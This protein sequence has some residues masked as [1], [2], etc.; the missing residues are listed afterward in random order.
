M[1]RGVASSS[2][3]KRSHNAESSASGP[4][5]QRS[6]SLHA[7]LPSQ[8]LESAD[9]KKVRKS[10]T[11]PKP[12]RICPEERFDFRLWAGGSREE[13]A[14]QKIDYMKSIDDKYP[15]RKWIIQKIEGSPYYMECIDSM[16]PKFSSYTRAQKIKAYND[17]PLAIPGS[18]PSRRTG[19]TAMG[20]RTT[21]P[22]AG[23]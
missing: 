15:L 19:G 14:K 5:L 12:D 18:S 3:S 4:V 2:S 11:E 7:R 21:P 9:T 22:Q 6:K 17:W 20:F 23:S 1:V 13:G 10:I 16:H 8:S